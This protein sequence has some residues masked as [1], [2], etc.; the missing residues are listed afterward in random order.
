MIDNVYM[1]ED[2]GTRARLV[3]AGVELLEHGG[4][5]A[6]GL[7]A[8]TR[9]AGVSHGAPRRYFPTHRALLAAIA[10]AGFAD[11]RAEL[12]PALSG[13]TEPTRARLLEMA[14]LY[15]AF[16]RRRPD[17]FTLIFRHDLLEGA[18]E[19]L[20]DKTVPVV[21]A[22][23]KL[24]GGQAESQRALGLWASVHGIAMLTST[25]ALDLF[26]ADVDALIV[27]AVDS[28]GE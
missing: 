14:R 10:E 9:A 5:A 21:D 26:D 3:Q 20:R 17:M 19:D 23:A 8:I 4:V 12:G 16:A 13:S 28:V 24:V 15:V 1:A 18:G 6:V 27:A 25:R 7:R 2:L 11:L 22:L